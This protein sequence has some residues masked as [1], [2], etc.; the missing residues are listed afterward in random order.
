MPITNLEITTWIGIS[1]ECKKQAFVNDFFAG[2]G[3]EDL[4]KMT[5]QDVADTVTSYAKRTDGEFPIILSPSAKKDRRRA[6][7]VIEF[8]D[9]TTPAQFKTV[10]DEEALLRDEK[11][12]ARKKIGETYLDATFPAEL[13]GQAQWE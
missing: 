4:G 9:G 7:Q 10:I 13:K 5:K 11:R 2:G 12:D 1:T 3:L 8:P 6:G